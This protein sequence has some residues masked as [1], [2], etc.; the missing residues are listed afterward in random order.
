MQGLLGTVV[1]WHCASLAKLEPCSRSFFSVWL[2][3]RTGHVR[4]LPEIWRAAVRWEPLHL[5]SRCRAQAQHIS[6]VTTVDSS[7]WVVGQP[8]GTGLLQ[9]PPYPF[10]L[11][12]VLGQGPGSGLFW[13]ERLRSGHPHNQGAKWWETNNT[14]SSSLSSALLPDYLSCCPTATLGRSP[15]CRASPLPSSSLAPFCGLRN[16]DSLAKNNYLYSDLMRS[17]ILKSQ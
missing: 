5:Y 16:F 7:L 3:V 6:V 4:S 10:Q 9:L 17:P 15:R 13:R 11:F 14:G 1:I 2:L 8:P 12:W